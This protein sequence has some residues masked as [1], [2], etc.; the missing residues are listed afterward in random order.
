MMRSWASVFAILNKEVLSG[1]DKVGSSVLGIYS[2]CSS[3][4][5]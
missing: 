4:S 1:V 3:S 5:S 2:N